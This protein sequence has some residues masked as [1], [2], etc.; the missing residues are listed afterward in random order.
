MSSF[1]KHFTKEQANSGVKM[2]VKTP[3][4][5]TSDD[6]I[7]V[8]GTDSDAFARLEADY[9]EIALSEKSTTDDKKNA[10]S[11]CLAALIGGWSFDEDCNEK[12]KLEL[13]QQA[14]FIKDQIN[15]FAADRSNYIKKK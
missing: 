7:V 4:G 6:W 3:D 2:P 13:L 15:T 14:P 9:R 12:N 5:L 8:L 1:K 11:K 10:M